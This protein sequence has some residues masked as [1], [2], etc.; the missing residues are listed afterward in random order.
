MRFA[1]DLQQAAAELED[2]AA[3]RAER[4]RDQY[5]KKCAKELIDAACAPD[6]V[7]EVAKLGAKYTAEF[8]KGA[9]YAEDAGML[10]Q[11]CRALANGEYPAR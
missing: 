6:P 11:A 7:E 5:L 10:S 9:E 8:E 1:E 3:S 4:R 2:R